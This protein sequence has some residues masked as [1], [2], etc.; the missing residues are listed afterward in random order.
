M[1]VN[2][3]MREARRENLLSDTNFRLKVGMSDSL[4]VLIN[5]RIKGSALMETVVIIHPSSGQEWSVIKGHLMSCSPVFAR[6]FSNGFEE[7]FSAIVRIDDCDPSAITQFVDLV[8]FPRRNKTFD[9]I[10]KDLDLGRITGLL[11]KYDASD[12]MMPFI[13]QLIEASPR[14]SNITIADRMIVEH[15]WS[16]NMLDTIIKETMGF[17]ARGLYSTTPITDRHALSL[18]SST[19]LADVLVRINQSV[20]AAADESARVHFHKRKGAKQLPLP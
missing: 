1:N 15:K 18:L 5:H 2:S 7:S 16:S 20:V 10:A 4:A 12:A 3:K 9:Q 13:F 14:M 11:E 8:E 6:M 17:S 19:T